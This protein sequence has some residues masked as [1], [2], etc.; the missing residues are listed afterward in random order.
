V[1]IGVPKKVS[2]FEITPEMVT[3]LPQEMA[4]RVHMEVNQKQTPPMPRQDTLLLAASRG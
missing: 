3:N 2:V 4:T 1:Q